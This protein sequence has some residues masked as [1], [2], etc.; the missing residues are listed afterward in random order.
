MPWEVC[1]KLQTQQDAW[2]FGFWNPPC[3]PQGTLGQTRGHQQLLLHNINDSPPAQECEQKNNLTSVK[4]TPD[5]LVLQCHDACD[6]THEL[7]RIRGGRLTSL[8]ASFARCFAFWRTSSK[9]S[10]SMFFQK[11]RQNIASLRKKHDV[12]HDVFGFRNSIQSYDK[13]LVI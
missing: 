3:C 10:T 1:G 12:L 11:H 13:S 5:K 7:P 6:T 9:T 4:W 8:D 2:F